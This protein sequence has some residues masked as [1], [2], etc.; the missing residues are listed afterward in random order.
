MIDTLQ[1]IGMQAGR[2][3]LS[4]IFIF[5]GVTKIMNWSS[6]AESMSA[7][8]LVAVPFFL[9]AAIAVEVGAGFC[10]FLGYRPRQAALALALFLVPVT[11]IF[12]AFWTHS[13]AQERQNQMQHF[14]KNVTIIGGL[15]A[16]ASS[17]P[18]RRLQEIEWSHST[19]LGQPQ[20]VAVA[21]GDAV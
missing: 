7:A 10:L 1:R 21:A 12:H 17:A 16:V 14:M 18:R 4:L 9:A 8:G 3:A 13:D 5:A 20:R 19:A 6:T 15:I 11:L 2:M